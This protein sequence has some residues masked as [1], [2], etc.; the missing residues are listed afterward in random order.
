MEFGDE[1]RDGADGGQH[2]GENNADGGDGQGDLHEGVAMLIL[3]DDAADVAFVDEL[4]NLVAELVGLD[5]EFLEKAVEFLHGW[6]VAHWGA[7]AGA[8]APPAPRQRR[9]STHAVPPVLER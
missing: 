2:R 6:S 4:A 7:K 9:L 5:L 1:G 3:D 8:T